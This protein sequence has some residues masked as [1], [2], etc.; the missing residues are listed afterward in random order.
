MDF[1]ICKGPG[2]NP[3][4]IPREDT[5]SKISVETMI[6]K[7]TF[8]FLYLKGKCVGKQQGLTV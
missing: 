2:T 3:L 1:G 4:W 8:Y 5:I 7:K 6:C